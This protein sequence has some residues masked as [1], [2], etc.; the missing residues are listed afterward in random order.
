[1]PEVN[2]R[3]TRAELAGRRDRPRRNF[4]RRGGLPPRASRVLRFRCLRPLRKAASELSTRIAGSEEAE[5]TRDGAAN[6][7]LKVLGRSGRGH[8]LCLATL[9]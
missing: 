1:M 3:W 7:F 8:D 4:L 2:S 6:P 5:G 9:Q